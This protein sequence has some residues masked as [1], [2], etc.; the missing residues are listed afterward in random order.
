MAH[1]RRGQPLG[2]SADD[3][4]RRRRS[5]IRT[6]R[7]PGAAS[8]ATSPAPAAR[9]RSTSTA[10]APV[11]LT[12]GARPAEAAA[13]RIDMKTAALGPAVFNSCAASGRFARRSL[14]PRLLRR[15]ARSGRCAVQPAPAAGAAAAPW[16]AAARRR[17]AA[18]PAACSSAEAE[19]ALVERRVCA[20]A[21]GPA[22]A[23]AELDAASV[24][25]PNQRADGAEA[26]TADHAP[27]P[28][29]PTWAAL[30]DVAAAGFRTVPRSRLAG[31]RRGGRG[32]GAAAFGAGAIEAVVDTDA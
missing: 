28:K 5:A 30:A 14:F 24:R 10:T 25:D 20:P 18:R 21:P 19:P 9:A 12:I 3:G 26:P 4:R 7:R 13:D 16:R 15:H 2:F 8:A 23:E 27:A 11:R 29:P 32:R 31:A 22:A 17:A 1:A 6:T